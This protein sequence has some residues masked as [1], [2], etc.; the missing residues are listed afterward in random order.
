METPDTT[1]SAGQEPAANDNPEEREPAAI[2]FS[3]LIAASGSDE[4][5]LLARL[6]ELLVRRGAHVK[7][8]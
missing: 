4:D 5:T 2:S 8:V 3:D 1:P 6:A 7:P